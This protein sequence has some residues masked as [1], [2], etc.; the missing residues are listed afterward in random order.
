M[1]TSPTRVKSMGLLRRRQ[2]QAEVGTVYFGQDLGYFLVWNIDP[3]S[4][5]A[6]VYL[7]ETGDMGRLTLEHFSEDLQVGTI[8]HAAEFADVV[9]CPTCRGRVSI[10]RDGLVDGERAPFVACE[11]CAFCEAL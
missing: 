1:Q 10:V 7:C 2:E 8:R 3:A 5:R 6:D 4:N 11:R 9:K